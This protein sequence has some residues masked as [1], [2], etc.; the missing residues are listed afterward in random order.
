MKRRS[1]IRK[2]ALVTAGLG[3]SVPY[4]RTIAGSAS[5]EIG[6][7]VMGVNGRGNFLAGA[8]TSVPGVKVKFICDVD[9]RA[10]EKTIN[11]V[12]QAAGYKPK[13]FSDIRK[14]LEEK[15]LDALVVAAPDHWHAPAAIMGCAAGKNV[16]VEKPCCH[17]PAEGE[18]LVQAARKYNKLVQMGNQ[19]RS[20]PIYINA[21]KELHDGIIGRVYFARGWYANNRASIGT[22]KQAPVPEWLNYDLWQGP[23][24]RKDYQDNLIHYNW[25][26]FWH[27]G[28]S[29][30]CNNGTHEID[31][32]RWGLNEGYPVKVTSSGGRFRYKDDWQTPDTQVLTF[33]FDDNK[34]MVWE[35]RSCNNLNEEDEGRGVIFFGESGSMKLL[36]TRYSVLDNNNKLVKEESEKT[37]TSND[38]IN[39]VG[40]G[41]RF[42]LPHLRNFAESIR[43]MASLNSEIAEGYMSTMLPLYGNIANRVGRNL[44]IDP[45]SGKI[46]DDA[47]AMKF[48][49]REYEPGWEPK[50]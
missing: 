29:E 28:T 22:G 3:L 49:G 18:L 17:N 25:H 47:E 8:F 41:L 1:F 24:P 26:W 20:H 27:W 48:W 39:K 30:T 35:G 14:M 46:L 7:G 16:Y 45:G 9:S 31:V 34:S 36:N 44:N 6:I 19:R 15:D 13:G 2:S 42:D 38:L 43:G 40:P 21:I 4:I 11:S 5:D 32:M 33:D 23:A 50:G 12:N 37:D 10:L